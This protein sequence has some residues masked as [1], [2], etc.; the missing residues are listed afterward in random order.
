MPMLE[1]RESW[2]A[3]RIVWQGFRVWMASLR[4][5]EEA[6]AQTWNRPQVHGHKRIK[7]RSQT[8]NEISC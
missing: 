2:M 3:L 5:E 4:P 8:G 1:R 6:A 7:D